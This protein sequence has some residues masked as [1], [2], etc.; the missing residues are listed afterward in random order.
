MIKKTRDV[1]VMGILNITDNS[2]YPDSRCLKDGHLSIRDVLLKTE[3]LVNEGAD[4]LDIGACSTRPGFVAVGENVEWN[5]LKPVLSAIRS[6]FKG[7]RISIDT[8]WASVVEK[9]YDLIGDFIVNDISAGEDDDQM[10]RLVGKLGLDYIAMHKRGNALTMQSLCDYDNVSL[11]ILAYF[12]E[13]SIK[14]EQAGV[15]NWILDP[16]FGFAKNIEQN[17]ELLRNLA[18]F[19]KTKKKILVGLSRKSMIYKYLNI[20]PEDSLPE[21][22]ILNMKALE[23]G[24]D[25]LRVHDVAQAKRTVK[26]YRIL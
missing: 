23:N 12:Q 21:T 11:E 3:V 15:R 13:F 7:V 1:S 16:G 14:A 22:Q 6:E 25:I 20:N 17:Y 4:I 24:A 2:F 10:L 9:S 19:T 26:L 18:L 8:Y 5:R